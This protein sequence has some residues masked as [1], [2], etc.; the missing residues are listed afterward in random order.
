MRR[1]VVEGAFFIA[2]FC[3]GTATCFAQWPFD[4][5]DPHK[6]FAEDHVV[7]RFKNSA[8]AQRL[9]GARDLGIQAAES[10]LGLPPGAELVETAFG[11]WRR[12][13]EGRV[14]ARG[15]EPAIDLDRFVYVRVPSHMTATELVD[16][17]NQNPNVEYAQVD[18][19][20]TGG[21]TIPDDHLFSAQWWHLNNLYTSSIPA[22]IRTV[23]AW[24]VTQGTS[25]VI[26]AVLDTG[27]NT[28]LVEFVGRTVPGHDFAYDDDDPAD[29]HDHGTA[30]TTVMGARGNNATN[31]AG[32]NWFCRIM[33][34]KVLNSGNVGQYSWWAEGIDWAVT[35]GAKVINLSAGGSGSQGDTVLSNAIMN[36]V[37][38]GVIFVT[39]THNFNTGVYYPGEMK[40]CITIGA[41][42]T[43][44][45]RA[46]FSN[47]GGTTDL[48]AP[49]TK[50]K[51]LGK[52]GQILNNWQGTSFSAP[53]VAGAAA[54][55]ADWHP[56]IEQDQM[57]QLLRASADDQVG[58]PSVD[59]RGFDKYHGSG[60]LNVQSA[61][62]LAT[63]NGN[64]VLR[65]AYVIDGVRS[66]CEEDLQIFSERIELYAD[67]N[68]R[69]LYV[70]CQDA[71]DGRDHFILVTDEPSGWSNSP[72]AK[73]GQVEGLKHYL[74]DEDDN[75]FDGWYINGV[76]NTNYL[77]C[78][79][80]TDNGYLEGTIDLPDVFGYI[81]EQLYISAAPYGSHDGGNLA[82]NWITPAGNDDL[83]V[84]S[85]EY[86][87]FKLT[88]F[89]TDGD[90]LS[91]LAEDANAD[92]S[93][94]EGESGA[95]VVDSDGDGLNDGVEVNTYGTSPTSADSDGDGL[96]DEDELVAGCNPTNG[97]SF[98]ESDIEGIANSPVSDIVI[99][100]QGIT[101]RLYTVYY[102]DDFP[103]N[104]ESWL[105]T[106]FQ[107]EPG[108]AGTMTY[109]NDISGDPQM[110]RYYR[111]SVSTP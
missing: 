2:L 24:D 97:M 49:G 59:V 33:P 101:G 91:D 47:Y 102:S 98:F 1:V 68:G 7:V 21:T 30:V 8:V 39:I 83:N 18:G 32:V 5:P 35:N 71:G 81:P 86:Y 48:V 103:T 92:G 25:N 41:T 62:L 66:P 88:G 31:F 77:S 94:S 110:Q 84:A 15:G 52:D 76:L 104:A 38:Q 80:P 42:D 12:Q 93:M 90:G 111:V 44:D 105:A 96:D 64:E 46:S 100:W 13:R 11:K 107:D 69:E 99:Q 89:D 6:A 72:W 51:T 73:S 4:P 53:L 10:S 109:T 60:R 78:S 9:G 56:D 43:N 22:D 3:L 23:E 65:K 54:L 55:I 14:R 79:R 34:I 28:S 29:D 67:F 82:K 20:G 26:V 36:A 27:L 108:I 50:I 106:G 63:N 17:L 45:Q 37:A 58:N 74:A 57:C 75:N 87:I 95:R 40:V 19:I 16:V 61:L 85:N 70:A